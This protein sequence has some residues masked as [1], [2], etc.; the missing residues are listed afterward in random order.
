MMDRREALRKLAAATATAS[1]LGWDPEPMLAGLLEHGGHAPAPHHHM[2]RTPYRFQTLDTRQRATVAALAEMI[3]PTTDTPGAKDAAIDEFADIILSEWSNDAEKQSFLDGL[4]ALDATVM[5]QFG[6][7]F[8]DA[9]PEQRLEQL[10]AMD[11]GLTAA[12][13]ARQA[14]RRDSGAPQPPDYR[15]LFF[16][17]IRS[18]T[19]SGY[20]ASEAGYT[21]ERK[22]VLIPGVYKPCMPMAGA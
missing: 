8:V 14:W 22:Q 16:H 1:F 9:T 2:P 11:A 7:P 15:Q 4:T 10:T 13:A 19:V 21:K 17:Q 12:R 20:Y 3:I 6:K 5:Q 18:L